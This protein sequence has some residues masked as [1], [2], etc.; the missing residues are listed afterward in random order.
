MARQYAEN[1]PARESDW[2]I[3]EVCLLPNI[4]GVALRNMKYPGTAYNQPEDA[5]VSLTSPRNDPLEPSQRE[6]EH[7]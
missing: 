7:H 3:G 2:L 5:K 1:K 6:P 4:K